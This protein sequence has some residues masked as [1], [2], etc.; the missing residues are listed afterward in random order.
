MREIV[1]FT[2]ETGLEVTITPDDVRNVLCPNA[3]DTEIALFLE[4]CASQHL[5][6]FIRD[7]YL[8]KYKQDQPAQ[9]VTGKAVFLKRAQA[10]PRFK[11]FKAGVVYMDGQGRVNKREGGAVYEIAGER[12]IGGWCEVL[13]EKMQPVYNEV[14]LAEYSTGRSMWKDAQNGGKPATMIRKVALCQS[15][16]EA[17]PTDFQGMYS[18]EEAAADV[19]DVE[20]KPANVE[21]VEII[22]EPVE[23]ELYASEEQLEHIN[24]LVFDI[25]GYRNVSQ[26]DVMEQ[27]LNC[28]AMVSAGVKRGEELTVSQAETAIKQLSIWLDKAIVKTEE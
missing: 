26:S 13:L 3:T 14:S 2:S 11:G 18:E 9:M 28:R 8:V 27:L 1:K 25:A 4:L 23:P 12:L 17:M 19:I 22:A 5:N 15:L 7:A 6:P 10:N 21:P 24:K 16:R 20:P